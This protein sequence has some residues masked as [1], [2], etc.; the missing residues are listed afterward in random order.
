VRCA[1]HFGGAA[2]PLRR[3][4]KRAS[5]SLPSISDSKATL[6]G[7]Q[8]SSGAA[9]RQGPLDQGPDD[10][11]GAGGT[12][13]DGRIVGRSAAMLKMVKALHQIFEQPRGHHAVL[14]QGETGTGKGH[15][16]RAIHG[17]SSRRYGPLIE[18]NCAVI[19]HPLLHEHLFG[20]RPS[21]DHPSGCV[22][23]LEAAHGGTLLLDQVACLSASTQAA[24][25]RFLRH[26]K[27]RRIGAAIDRLPDVQLIAA[28][29]RDLG[30]MAEQGLFLDELLR[31]LQVTTVT[32]PPLRA[33]GDDPVELA[34]WFLG[35]FA[36]RDGQV[37]KRLTTDARHLIR[38]YDWPGN[39]RQLRNVIERI[40]LIEDDPF[41]RAEQL[42]LPRS[43]D[44]STASRNRTAGPGSISG[45]HGTVPESSPSIRSLLKGRR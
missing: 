35:V 3:R 33:R 36:R 44:E 29:H 23:R 21:E 18:L 26:G 34:E 15:V 11:A 20:C 6:D 24:L 30:F 37:A 39:V 13:G 17:N 22:G 41:V 1:P 40:V 8:R 9:D 25:L 32:L 38:S 43:A 12:D 4:L 2:A 28:T 16:A 7:Q 42:Q 31:E 27:V 45:I 19:P 10:L 14:L 5:A